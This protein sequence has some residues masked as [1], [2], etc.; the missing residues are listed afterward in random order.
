MVGA[1]LPAPAPW[2]WRASPNSSAIG[3]HGKLAAGAHGSGYTGTIYR[4]LSVNGYAFQFQPYNHEFVH[5]HVDGTDGHASWNGALCKVQ[6]WIQ[7]VT[8]RRAYMLLQ[9]SSS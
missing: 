8:W 4:V 1:T 7:D 5:K 9:E 3:I 2:L 6:S